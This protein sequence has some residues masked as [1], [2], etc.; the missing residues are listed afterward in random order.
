MESYG[1]PAP[2]P[3]PPSPSAYHNP[4]RCSAT[5]RVTVKEIRLL[6]YKSEFCVALFNSFSG[7]NPVVKTGYAD[8]T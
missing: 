6:R 8:P 7:V 5:A 2:D 4:E 1:A 3:L